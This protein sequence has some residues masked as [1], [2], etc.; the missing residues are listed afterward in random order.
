LNGY[1][2]SGALEN[3]AEMVP[4]AVI[5]LIINITKGVAVIRNEFSL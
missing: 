5:I 3:L 2:G 4:V 1:I